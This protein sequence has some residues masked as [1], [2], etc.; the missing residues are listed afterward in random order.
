MSKTEAE[1]LRNIMKTNMTRM[2]DI[3]KK[4]PI[5]LMIV[6]RNNNLLRSINMELKTPVNRFSIMARVALRGIYKGSEIS[7]FS[8]VKQKFSFE[9]NLWKN[10]ILMSLFFFFTSVMIS[11]GFWE[12]LVI[13]DDFVDAS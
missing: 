11:L 7:F 13:D 4:I 3:F 6:L 9:F 5:P 1:E 12:P 2:T 10:D 8:F